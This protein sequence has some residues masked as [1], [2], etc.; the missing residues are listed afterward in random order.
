[1]GASQG[2][3][4]TFSRRMGRKDEERAKVTDQGGGFAFKLGDF[5]TCL[6]AEKGCQRLRVGRCFRNTCAPVEGPDQKRSRNLERREKM[7]GWLPS[8]A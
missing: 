5:W 7:G 1:M 6:K 8:L 2:I 4:V 3:K